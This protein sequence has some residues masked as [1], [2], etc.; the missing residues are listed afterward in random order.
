MD[1]ILPQISAIPL[2]PSSATAVGHGAARTALGHRPRR[3]G[4]RGGWNVIND[5]VD[6]YNEKTKMRENLKNQDSTGDFPCVFT[7]LP[8]NEDDPRVDT[9]IMV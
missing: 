9:H 7:C 1:R 3:R 8:K 2:P 6:K 4:A 5:E